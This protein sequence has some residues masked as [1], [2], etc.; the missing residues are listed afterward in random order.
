MAK[1]VLDILCKLNEAGQTIIMVT[2]EL[3][4]GEVADRVITLYDGKIVSYR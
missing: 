3:E 2:H 1:N 4:Y